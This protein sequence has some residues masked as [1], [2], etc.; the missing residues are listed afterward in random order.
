MIR[1][2]WITG[3][4]V[5]FSVFGIKAGLGLGAQI[6]SRSVSTGKKALLLGG[7]LFLYLI[8][9]VLLYGLIGHFHLLSYLD[10]FINLLQ[11]GMVLHL[12][13]ACGLLIWGA[14]LL[15]KGHEEENA[16]P[17]RG[18]LLLIAPCPVCATVILLNLTLAYSLFEFSP[19][20]TTLLLFAL[21][22]G[23][24]MATMGFLFPFRR[25]IGS[26]DSFLGLS[27]T[28]VSLYF[29]LTVVIAP[30]YPEIKA[31]F[32]MAVSNS[33]VN[34]TDPVPTAIFGGVALILGGV[35]FIRT[36]FAGGAI[37]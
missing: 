36:Y 27:M 9:F 20:L 26:G 23:V 34:Q 5:A 14:R 29:L 7:S 1:Q 22:M 37:Q 16:R 12:A 13:V 32:A 2:L 17:L 8:L 24:M 35:G 31:A 3:V 21:F 19:P 4:L 18:S 30:I 11:Y 25:H 10:Q 33:P 15:L 6:Y 28:F